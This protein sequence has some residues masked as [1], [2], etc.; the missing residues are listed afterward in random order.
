MDED[1]KFIGDG[2][3]GQALRKADWV[4]LVPNVGDKRITRS[5]HRTQLMR[6]CWRAILNM[7]K[8]SRFEFWIM[9]SQ[10]KSSAGD[11][12]RWEIRD[13]IPMH[14]RLFCNHVD[15]HIYLRTWEAHRKPTNEYERWLAKIKDHVDDDDGF[16]ESALDLS[17]CI[18]YEWGVPA[19]YR[20]LLAENILARP[21]YGR[22]DFLKSQEI[23][24]YNAL[25]RLLDRMMADKSTTIIRSAKPSCSL[26]HLRV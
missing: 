2:K 21:T 14:F 26:M 9:P 15:T 11:I 12:Q 17:S 7:P 23:R 13:I 16:H 8:L 22:I 24:S 1:P 4:D 6:Q 20:R 19:D 18:P 5:G 10:G 25:L 3:D